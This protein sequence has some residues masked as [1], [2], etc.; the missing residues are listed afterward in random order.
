M[1][2][3]YEDEKTAK[4]EFNRRRSTLCKNLLRKVDELEFSV[5]SANCLRRFNIEYVGDL[6]QISQYDMLGL[7]DFGRRSLNEI[8]EVLMQMDLK[9]GTDV[10]E[11]PED[12][13]CEVI[14]FKRKRIFLTKLKKMIF[15]TEKKI[16]NKEY[17]GVNGNL[18]LNQDV[19]EM[20]TLLQLVEVSDPTLVLWE[21]L[22]SLIRTKRNTLSKILELWQGRKK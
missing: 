13:K 18:I 8:K 16:Y 15:D 19:I 11:L 3:A 22:G 14:E 20:R 6:I 2:L 12:I 17:K 4:E 5:R 10:S 1:L 21:K 7:S 9:L